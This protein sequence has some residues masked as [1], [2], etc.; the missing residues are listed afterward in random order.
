MRRDGLNSFIALIAIAFVCSAWIHPTGSLEARQGQPGTLS[1]TDISSVVG[2]DRQTDGSH[3]AMFADIDGDG[4]PDLY[5]TYNNI[6]AGFRANRFYRNV[7][8]VFADEAAV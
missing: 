4:T 6:R 3:G 1:F 7:N 5:L 8:G 2:I